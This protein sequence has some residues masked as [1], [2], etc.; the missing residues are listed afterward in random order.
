MRAS[1]RT[2][3]TGSTWIDFPNVTLCRWAASKN[4]RLGPKGRCR[5]LAR[6]RCIGD[7]RLSSRVDGL[8]RRL[9]WRRY[10]LRHIGLRDP[11]WG[12]AEPRTRSFLSHRFLYPTRTASA[13]RPHCGANSY[14][15]SRR[16]HSVTCGA[17]EAGSK[18]LGNHGIRCQ[19]LFSRSS[20]LLRQ[21]GTHAAA[22]AHVVTRRRGAILHRSAVDACR[23]GAPPCCR[24]G[25]RPRQPGHRVFRLLSSRLS[26]QRKACFL[27]TA[28]PFLGVRHWRLCGGC[29]VPLRTRPQGFESR[30][31]A[32]HGRNRSGHLC[33]GRRLRRTAMGVRLGARH[34]GCHCSRRS[35]PPS[36]V[37]DPGLKAVGYNWASLLFHLPRALAPD[38]VLAAVCSPTA[39]SLRTGFDRD[40]L[41]CSRGGH[42]AHG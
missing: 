20:R 29:R 11:P 9:C 31:H 30:R 4:A 35:M 33:S 8:H 21:R 12:P 2:T 3:R 36:S 19:L 28:G 17:Y 25:H 23:A 16:C 1:R 6:N 14:V 38:R 5:W 24:R 26:D 22:A 7:P 18:R 40:C 10:L 34:G 42:L 37:D 39:C 41:A 27:H 32:W 13:P 15:G